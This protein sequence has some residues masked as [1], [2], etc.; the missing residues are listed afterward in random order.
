MANYNDGRMPAAPWRH[1]FALCFFG[2][3]STT[4][5]LFVLFAAALII[6]GVFE[7]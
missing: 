1:R 7:W 2:V 6:S 3:V 5:A 4:F